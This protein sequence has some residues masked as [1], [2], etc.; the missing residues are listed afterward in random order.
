M[1]KSKAIKTTGELREF[2][3]DTMVGVKE[4]SIDTNKARSIARLAGQINDGFY[5]EVMSAK[6][7]AEAGA[8]IQ[9]LGAMALN[10]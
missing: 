7:R 5:A 8:T 9:E 6:M 10:R 2:L 3:A 4:G 1:S